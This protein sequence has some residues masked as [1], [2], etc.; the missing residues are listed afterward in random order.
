M[1][2]LGLSL[3]AACAAPPVS[4]ADPYESAN[5]KVH[6]FNQALDRGLI[7]PVA[8]GIAPVARSPV[9]T[10]VTNVADNLSMPS[11]ILNK[12]LQGK[13]EDAVHNTW[14][15]AL[16]TT[17]GIGGIFDPAGAMGLTEREADFG[18][19]LH[20]WGAGEGGFIMLP[21]AGPST[22]RDALGLLVDTVTDPVGHV[23]PSREGRWA[24]GINLGSKLVDRA[25]FG[26]TV[27]SIL[28]ESAD[29]YAQTRLLYLQ[30]RRFELGQEVAD[31]AFIDPYADPDG[32]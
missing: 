9:G 8:R 15:F 32:N 16:N 6:A 12:I 24:T 25:R 31:D 13:A 10:A 22:E 4:D 1:P 28:H 19:T 21:V 14:R 18:G 26:D 29:S 20:T 11:I 2:I 23:L 5:R 17:L 3:L 30:N 7:R 27:D